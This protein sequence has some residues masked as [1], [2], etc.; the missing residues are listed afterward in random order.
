[1]LIHSER[2]PPRGKQAPPIQ[3]RRTR[4]HAVRPHSPPPPSPQRLTTLLQH[5]AERPTQER[6]V[7]AIAAV[8]VGAKKAFADYFDPVYALMRHLLGQTASEML[9]LRARAMECVGLMCLAVG[10]DRCSH[11]LQEV[12]HVAMAGLPLDAPELREYTFGFF[13]QARA[14]PPPPP[15]PPP[16]RKSAG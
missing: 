11:V 6:C 13:G 16:D 10:R 15:P 4:P 2:T 8:A 1:M 5:T 7:S 3:P 12:V 14:S 9:P